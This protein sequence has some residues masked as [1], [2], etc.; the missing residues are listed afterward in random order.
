MLLMQEWDATAL[1][2][3]YSVAGTAFWVLIQSET[4]RQTD[5]QRDHRRIDRQRERQLER[6]TYYTR[7]R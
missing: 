3:I 4:D 1:A 5:R 7:D 6:A 2:S